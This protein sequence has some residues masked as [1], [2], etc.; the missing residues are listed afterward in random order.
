M[1]GTASKFDVDFSTSGGSTELNIDFLENLF[2]NF[3][4][5]KSKLSNKNKTY[6]LIKLILSAAEP[7]KVKKPRARNDVG[8]FTSGGS[9]ELNADIF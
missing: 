1:R 7:P 8:F 3:K 4:I 2:Y 9:T 6:I 5:T